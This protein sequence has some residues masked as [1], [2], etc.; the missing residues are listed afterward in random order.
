[1]ASAQYGS[2]YT[3]VGHPQYGE[4]LDFSEHFP[5]GQPYQEDGGAGDQQVSCY[6]S[7]SFFPGGVADQQGGAYSYQQQ[8]PTNYAFGQSGEPANQGFTEGSYD[9]TTGKQHQDM[10]QVGSYPDMQGF[11][12]PSDGY[13]DAA[14]GQFYTTVQP[15]DTGVRAV[16]EVLFAGSGA[17][18]AIP[19]GHQSTVF[20]KRK[21]GDCNPAWSNAFTTRKDPCECRR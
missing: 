19:L 15:S 6:R 12:Q 5:A 9:Y 10:G 2:P 20:R 7:G 16:A 21:S 3:Y 14:A 13:T 17:F 4:G 8:Q 1:M 18:T 11:A